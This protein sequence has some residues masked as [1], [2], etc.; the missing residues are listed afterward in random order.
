M[1]AKVKIPP[2]AQSVI[3]Y[4]EEADVLYVSFGKPRKAEGIDI[5]DGTILRVDPET[6][7]IVGITILDFKKRTGEDGISEKGD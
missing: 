5:G 4:D 1:V 3:N 6:G 2:K 7:Q